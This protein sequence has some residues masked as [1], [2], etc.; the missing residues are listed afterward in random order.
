[1]QVGNKV[2]QSILTMTAGKVVKRVG[3]TVVLFPISAANGI[4]RLSKL[5][6][7]FMQNIVLFCHW[8]EKYPY[9]SIHTDVIPSISKNLQYQEMNRDS[10]V[11]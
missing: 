5:L 6:H 8:L 4:E 11:A 7:R 2:R 9:R 1:M 10:S 3:I